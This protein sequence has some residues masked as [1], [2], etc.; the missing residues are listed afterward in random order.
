MCHFGLDVVAKSWH[1]AQGSQKLLP[2][3]GDTFWQIE[4]LSDPLSGKI[5]ITAPF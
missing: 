3:S 4:K 1:T 2:T 5:V